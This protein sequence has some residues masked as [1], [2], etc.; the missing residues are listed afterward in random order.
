MRSKQTTTIKQAADILRKS[1]RIALFAHTNPDG[2]TIGAC[3]GL[4]LILQKLGK[5]ADVFC[6]SELNSRLSSFEESCC[7]NK[8]FSGIKYDLMVAVDCSD[9]YRLGDFSSIYNDCRTTLTI[10]HHGD[11]YFSAYN[12]IYTYSSTCQ[13]IYEIAKALGVTL[14]SVSATYLYL[15]LCTDTGNFAYNVNKG[16]FVM[17]SELCEIGADAERIYRVFFREKSLTEIKLLAR[18]LS[19]IRSYYDDKMFLLYI[20]ADDLLEFG[21][22]PSTTSGIVSYAIDISTAKAGVCICEF[23]PNCYK[24]SMRGKDYSVREVCKEFGGGGHLYAS[25]C[26]INGMLEDVIEKIVRVVGYTI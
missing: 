1:N 18:A 21:L 10:D 9:I 5:S 15:G 13:I 11:D 17:A 8:T 12:C 24:V 26:R 19:R 25:G 14:D 2:D 7:V 16:G 22:E 3:I 6:D 23:A 20:T 4:K